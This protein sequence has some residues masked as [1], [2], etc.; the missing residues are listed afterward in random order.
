[1]PRPPTETFVPLTTAKPGR[2]D[3]AEYDVNVVS[4]PGALQTFK[5]LTTE[6][7]ALSHD[8]KFTSKPCD[9]R[10]S[11]QRDGDQVTSIRIQCGCGQVIDLACVY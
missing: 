3:S 5:P 8:T 2:N 7:P 4:Q 9:P 10:I 1:M 6:T 11:I